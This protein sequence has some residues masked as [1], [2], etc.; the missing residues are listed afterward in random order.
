M[1]TIPK[2]SSYPITEHKVDILER[3]DPNIKIG[4]GGSKCKINKK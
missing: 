3:L 1:I 4:R 2:K